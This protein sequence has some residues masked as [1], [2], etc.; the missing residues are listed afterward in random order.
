MAFRIATNIASQEVQKNL[1]QVSSKSQESLAKLSSGS[2][3]NKAADNA[4]G[5]AISKRFEANSLGLAQAARNASEGISYVQ[6][7]EG[8]LNES[9]NII[10]RLRELS[11]QAASSTID[12]KGRALLDLERQQLLGEIDRIAESSDF[13]GV[14]L[15]NGEGSSDLSFHVGANAGDENKVHYDASQVDATTSNLGIDS[16]DISEQEGAEDGIQS[17]DSALD[18]V[19]RFRAELGSI[20]SRLQSSVNNLQVQK[21]NTDNARSVIQDTDVAEETSKLARFNIIEKAGIASLAS[22]NGLPNSV[23]RLIG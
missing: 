19:S 2:R 18:Q 6:T 3:I 12:D 20:Q 8:A 16:L 9:S 21:I 10:V 13:N 4:A 23:L 15:I 1:S 17:L 5:L 11:I 7:A 22:A 14:R